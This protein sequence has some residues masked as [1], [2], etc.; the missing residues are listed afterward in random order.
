M[1]INNRTSLTPK[2]SD[3]I[4]SA[5]DSFGQQLKQARVSKDLSL[6]DVAGELFILKRHLEAI[7]SE[8]FSELPQLAFARGFVVNYAKFL[9]LDPEQIAE[10]F[11][12]AY[13]D[14][15]KKKSVN[16]IESPLRPMGT[17]QREGR[18]SIRFNPL[19]VI[20]LVAL[21]ALAVFLIRTVT[22]AEDA[23]AV[24]GNSAA[25]GDD[26]SD[27]EQTAGAAL[28]TGSAVDLD[29]SG[30]ALN[31]NNGESNVEKN[32]EANGT[33]TSGNTNNDDQA[34]SQT[35][36]ADEA[37]LE[38]WIM[39]NTNVNVTDADGNRLLTGQQTRGAYNLS[40]KPPFKV[41]IDNVSRVTLNLNKQP[42]QLN[43][44]AKDNKADFTL[45]P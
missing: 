12:R 30:S 9:D 45:A 39:G 14:N 22:S 17:L 34:A 19:L 26:L 28:S 37:N 7:E 29:S 38:F 42:I 20:G 18:R 1:E 8:S 16:D 32:A 43:K 2:H 24:K 25:L 44:F 15:L 33:N 35:V 21:I 11:N 5:T 3:T 31:L 40:G 6:D 10:S 4:K 41:Q 13:P 27:T 23:S 36:N